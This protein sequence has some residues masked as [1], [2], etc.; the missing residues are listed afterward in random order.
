[1]YPSTLVARL[2]MVI[3][4]GLASSTLVCVPLLDFIHTITLLHQV[5]ACSALRSVR[6]DFGTSCGVVGSCPPRSSSMSAYGAI[7]STTSSRPPLA[8]TVWPAKP[9]A[10]GPSTLTLHHLTLA[11]ATELPGL[12]DCLHSAFAQ[13][14][15]E[16]ATYPQEIL[17]GEEYKRDSFDAYFFAGDVIVAIVGHEETNHP[18]QG[19]PG[20]EVQVDIKAAAKGRPWEE[21]VAGFY[22]AR[23]L[24]SPRHQGRKI[25]II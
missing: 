18:V 7:A 14:I 22:Y 1:M 21:C 20:Q 8:S 23:S 17:A 5:N 10:T 6:Y 24:H 11:R 15:E 9:S 25:D 16:G 4:D 3:S 12:L 19:A 13:I 2:A